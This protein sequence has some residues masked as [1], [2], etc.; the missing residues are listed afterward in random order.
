MGWLL[1]VMNRKITNRPVSQVPQCTRH[2]SHNAL[3][4]TEMFKHVHYSVTKWCIVEH[5]TKALWDF[6]NFYWNY[7]QF[8]LLK[9]GS[10]LTAETE[11]PWSRMEPNELQWLTTYETTTWVIVS[12]LIRVTTGRVDVPRTEAHL[13]RKR[14][15]SPKH[16][17]P[18]YWHGL[19]LINLMDKLSHAQ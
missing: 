9:D 6:W 19:T 5:G 18:F 2:M 8:Q 11:L 17:G 7:K 1:R 3:F 4:L 12:N 13:Q 15:K 10:K 14:N 16:Q